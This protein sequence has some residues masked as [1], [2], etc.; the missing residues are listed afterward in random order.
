M[1]KNSYFKGVDELAK[2]GTN[3]NET[4]LIIW[5]YKYFPNGYIETE[6]LAD[7]LGIDTEVQFELL[8]RVL[9]TLK[10]QK[11]LEAIIHPNGHFAWGLWNASSTDTRIRTV[12]EV[13]PGFPFEIL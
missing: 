6:V 7:H 12:G 3:F 4:N 10:Q 8:I 11:K 13:Y 9:S 1:K 2:I 5:F